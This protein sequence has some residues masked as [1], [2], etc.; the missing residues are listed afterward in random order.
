MGS[1]LRKRVRM[2]SKSGAVASTERLSSRGVQSNFCRNLT[3]CK[4]MGSRDGPGQKLRV[5]PGKLPMSRAAAARRPAPF[6]GIWKL[7]AC[8]WLSWA[9]WSELHLDL[10]QSR[11]SYS[12]AVMQQPGHGNS[13]QQTIGHD[14]LVACQLKSMSLPR[15]S[16]WS[17]LSINQSY[18]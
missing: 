9:R 3:C 7:G 14:N 17:L 11:G 10:G 13:V 12:C 18:S 8:D 16:V 4:A 2:L 1:R 15:T 6:L 5:G